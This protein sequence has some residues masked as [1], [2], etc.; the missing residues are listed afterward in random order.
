MIKTIKK[1]LSGYLIKR[2]F[3]RLKKRF[4]TLPQDM[5]VEEVINFE[6]SIEGALI[7]P[8]QF[9]SEITKL[10]S[11]FKG[12][13]PQCAMEIG[14][15]N[16]GTLFGHCRL[17]PADSTIISLDLPGGQYGGGY[18]EWKTEIYSRFAKK[19]QRL[20]LIRGDSH[21]SD[22]L[23]KVMEILNN[24]RLDYLLIDGDHSYEGVKLDFELYS[25]LVR[26]G[27]VVAFHDVVPHENSSCKV[28]KFWNEIKLKYRHDEFIDDPQQRCYG[29]GVLYID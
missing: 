13:K 15:A 3:N 6:Y 19:D 27:G 21:H 29:V 12:I 14:T 1:Q 18:P 24:K 8:W 9:K 22:S 10:F 7:T 16:G 5:S 23:K 25:P 28:D 20:H 4:Q 2:G 11:V 17:A 26:K